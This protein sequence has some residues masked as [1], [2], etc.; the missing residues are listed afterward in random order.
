M[1]LNN[2]KRGASLL[3]VLLALVI[4]LIVAIGG[5]AFVYY[6]TGAVGVERNKRAALEVANARLEEMK[7][8]DYEDIIPRETEDPYLPIYDYE[9]HIIEETVSIN[10]VDR[11]MDTTVQYVDVDGGTPSYDYLL[12]TV[13]V[14]Y[15]SNSSGVV[16]L[17]TYIG[18]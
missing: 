6:S 14:D 9:E 2:S 12:V 11:P 5:G 17:Q 3:E 16:T 18:P 4:V 15:S 7:A 8:R 1:S 10:G 13:D